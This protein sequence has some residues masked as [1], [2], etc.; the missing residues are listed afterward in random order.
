MGTRANLAAQK[1]SKKVPNYP[2]RRAAESVAGQ[3]LGPALKRYAGHQVT[4]LLGFWVMVGTFGSPEALITSGILS[5]SA[6]YRQLAE[7]RQTFGVELRD[8]HPELL[9]EF[10]VLEGQAT[11][12]GLVS[13]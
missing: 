1:A 4:R 13:S 11:I 12:P 3:L 6:V 5:K 7:F 10:P 8:W 9:R 2:G